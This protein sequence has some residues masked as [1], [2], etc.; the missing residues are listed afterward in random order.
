MAPNVYSSHHISPRLV[1]DLTFLFPRQDKASGLY[2]GVV[3]AS[4][5][6]GRTIDVK[7]DP[8][9]AYSVMCKDIPSLT[10]FQQEPYTLYNLARPNML[11]KRGTVDARLRQEQQKDLA[12]IRSPSADHGS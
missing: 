1:L 5:A 12:E 11:A 3:P 4:H 8:T 7:L 9:Q 2:Q 6:R 10:A